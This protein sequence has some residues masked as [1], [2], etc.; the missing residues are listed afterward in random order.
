MDR[1]LTRWAD[2]QRFLVASTPGEGARD[3]RLQRPEGGRVKGA[4]RGQTPCSGASPG[5]RDASGPSSQPRSTTRGI[6]PV[7]RAA[8]VDALVET[9]EHYSLRRATMGVEGTGMSEPI[10]ATRAGS[11]LRTEELPAGA[12]RRCIGVAFVKPV[13]GRR[14]GAC[15]PRPPRILRFSSSRSARLRG[16]PIATRPYACASEAPHVRRTF[17]G[18][19]QCL[20]RCHGGG[21]ARR[22][23]PQPPWSAKTGARGWASPTRLRLGSLALDEPTLVAPVPR[24]F[25]PM[26]AR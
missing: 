24:R 22:R 11:T 4:G 18:L 7:D 3:G 19:A 21:L 15:D 8:V 14:R 17:N 1:E 9:W 16:H 6:D 2:R 23:W 20:D 26:H 10:S 5:R 13:D 12:A 25:R